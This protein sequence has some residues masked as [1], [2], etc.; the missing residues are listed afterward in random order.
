MP[1]IGALMALA[2]DAAIWI[3]IYVYFAPQ[4]A[5]GDYPPL[6]RA[7]LLAPGIALLRP[8]RGQRGFR[9]VLRGKQITVFAT[10][11]TT[12]ALLLAAVSLAD[13]GPPA[14]IVIL[15]VVCLALSAACYAAVFTVFERAPEQRDSAIIVAR[16]NALVFAAWAAA[17]LLAGSFLCLPPLPADRAAG[18]GCDCGNLVR[19]PEEIAGLRVLWDGVSRG[20]GGGI[21]I[22]QLFRERARRD[23]NRHTGAGRLAGYGLRDSLL[24]GCDA[25]G[26]VKA[27]SRKLFILLLPLWPRVRQRR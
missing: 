23:A 12:I 7:A 13:F 4:G 1:E 5:S 8:L 2:A 14:G 16:R 22:V 6:A 3:L 9:T 27:G 18:R 26:K 17:L 11:Q 21:G 19:K 25:S 20:R 24:R 10:V 15:G